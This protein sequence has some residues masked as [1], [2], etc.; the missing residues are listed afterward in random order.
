MNLKF[1]LNNK[2]LSGS[3]E[4]LVMLYMYMTGYRPKYIG[5]SVKTTLKYWNEKGSVSSQNWIRAGHPIAPELNETLF[6]FHKRVYELIGQRE[7]LS[8]PISPERIA[9]E[10]K[11]G[12]L[13]SDL[14]EILDERII[15]MDS[16][17]KYSRAKM[18]N[19]ARLRIKQFFGS[20]LDLRDL[21]PK[22]IR[23]FEEFLDKEGLKARTV[24]YY[25][26]ELRAT[27]TEHFSLR[28]LRP[29]NNNPFELFKPSVKIKEN[30]K[31]VASYEDI[32]KLVSHSPKATMDKYALD[33]Y[34]FLYFFQGMR[35]ADVVTLKKQAVTID[36]DQISLYYHARKTA[37]ART[38]V[39]PPIIASRF[40]EY[41]NQDR[42]D[43]LVF[44][45]YGGKSGRMLFSAER[46]KKTS[47]R[48]SSVNFSFNRL[49][50]KIALAIGINKKLSMHT[51]RY[52]YAN[53]L[54]DESKDIRLVQG[55]LSHSSTSTTEIYL[56]NREDAITLKSKAI[57]DKFNT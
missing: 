30:K 28:N 15:E 7:I 35:F 20:S 5:T 9:A 32:A 36:R 13:K 51:A 43:D 17:K 16:Q 25:I 34:L 4:Y 38:I 48:V 26:N 2:P 41:F 55:A 45:F 10:L 19:S 50:A 22:T 3:S 27:Y 56:S 23:S 1:V 33:C 57:F 40:L 24:L 31:A 14:I 37:S 44:P 39:V 47:V 53:H 52:S 42:E 6:K 29:P 18:A 21:N 11:E 12:G 46:S 54:Y 49:L 8:M